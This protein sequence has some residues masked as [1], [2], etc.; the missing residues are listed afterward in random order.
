MND[1]KNVKLFLFKYISTFYA[2]A[3]LNKSVW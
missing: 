3:D 1:D 2:Q